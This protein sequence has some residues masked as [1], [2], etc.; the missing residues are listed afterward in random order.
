MCLDHLQAPRDEP[1][2]M[3]PSCKASL[4]LLT[5]VQDGMLSL[6]KITSKYARPACICRPA[7]CAARPSFAN[8]SFRFGSLVGRVDSVEFQPVR[9]QRKLIQRSDILLGCVEP[10]KVTVRPLCTYTERLYNH[11]TNSLRERTCQTAV[12]QTCTRPYAGV[13][14]TKNPGHY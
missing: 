7:T 13:L 14:L 3:F 2:G 4:L 12:S 1:L 8:P 10:R 5:S 6:S 11:C 9:A